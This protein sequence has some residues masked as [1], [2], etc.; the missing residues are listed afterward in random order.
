MCAA[1]RF[2]Q[3]LGAVGE[4]HGDD[5][6][7]CNREI[8]AEWPPR[9]QVGTGEPERHETSDADDEHHRIADQEPRVKPAQGLAAEAGQGSD[10]QDLQLLAVAFHGFLWV[11]RQSAE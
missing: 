11:C 5:E 1:T 8:D 3:R 4:Q 2:G 6:D 7:D 9:G 10:I